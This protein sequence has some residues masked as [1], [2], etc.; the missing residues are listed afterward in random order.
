MG[1]SNDQHVEV[2]KG[3][4]S[5]DVVA[6]NPNRPCSPRNERREAFSVA[7]KDAAK[8]DF[9]GD[10]NAKGAL[11][12]GAGAGAGP[13]CSGRRRRAQGRQEEAGRRRDAATRSCRS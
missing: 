6:M 11:P 5:G 1:I 10:P 4:K 13:G 3:I 7:A 12:K 9:S 2:K 8:K